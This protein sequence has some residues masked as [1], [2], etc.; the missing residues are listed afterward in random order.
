MPATKRAL[1]QAD[2]NAILPPK[3]KNKKHVVSGSNYESK[4]K[5][6]LVEIL[7][8]RF[9]PSNGTKEML[10][11]RLRENEGHVAPINSGKTE[12]R[13]SARIEAVNHNAKILEG[14]EEGLKTVKNKASGASSAPTVEKPPAES[15]RNNT[16]APQK[17]ANGNQLDYRTKDNSKLR[18]LLRD[19]RVMDPQEVES[20]DRPSMIERLERHVMRGYGDSYDQ[21]SPKN[22]SKLLKN[23]GLPTQGAKNKNVAIESLR[24]D[25]RS[26]RDTGNRDEYYMHH[27]LLSDEMD[28]ERYEKLNAWINNPT[29]AYGDL[30]L[31]LLNELW[32]VRDMGYLDD[33]CD[34]EK[35]LE[36]DDRKRKGKAGKLA[37][38]QEQRDK[39]SKALEKMK[40]DYKIS[41]AKLEEKIGQAIPDSEIVKKYGLSSSQAPVS[42]KSVQELGAIDYQ[43][44]SMNDLRE[45]CTSRGIQVKLH[46]RKQ[47]LQKKLCNNDEE[48]KIA[49][50]NSSEPESE[51]LDNETA[52]EPLNDSSIYAEKDN[53]MLRCLLRA[54]N[55]QVSGTRE[56]MI[57]RLDTSPYNY[58][59]YS[60]EKLALVLKDRHLA[61]A[62]YGSKEIKIERLKNSDKAI[63][64]RG[65]YNDAKLTVRVK[66]RE[67]GIQAK[68]QALKVLSDPGPSYENLKSDALR[69]LAS[70]FGL[71]KHG[72]NGAMIKRLQANDQKLN[73]KGGDKTIVHDA[74]K[75]LTDS[76]KA[77][78]DECDK[79]RKELEES[80]GHPVLDVSAA[81]KRHNAIS[82][83]DNEIVNSYQPARKPRP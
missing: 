5:E 39:I 76:L 67:D 65:S 40:R 24:M 26:D 75:K 62:K 16:S 20:M 54:R 12:R 10:I 46:D 80:V 83:R 73:L 74:I 63:C 81:T 49:E 17:S 22:L 71:S 70:V 66:L 27:K 1:A 68:E 23:R 6:E 48:D 25:D 78:K 41:R 34:I 33:D 52:Q 60:S 44:L 64:D 19:W 72:E 69:E 7:K 77:Q 18:T 15:S 53:S 8:G 35:C 57:H 50:E 42:P 2:T 11:R 51:P 13:K 61:N 37:H 31:E 9:M 29:K 14:C 36:K 59:S 30:D 56:E 21:L 4:S 45:M 55:L 79:A 32:G 47:D 3:K 43:S 38:E 28:I 58:E 82:N